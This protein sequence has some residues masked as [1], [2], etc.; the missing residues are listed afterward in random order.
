MRGTNAGLVIRTF[1]VAVGALS[2]LR[3]VRLCVIIE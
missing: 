1:K 2:Y 3:G